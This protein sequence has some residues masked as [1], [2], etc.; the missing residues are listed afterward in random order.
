MGAPLEGRLG[1]LIEDDIGF[2]VIN[3]EGEEEPRL[4]CSGDS[5]KIYSEDGTVFDGVVRLDS[6]ELGKKQYRMPGQAVDVLA[7]PANMTIDAWGWYFSTNYRAEFTPDPA[8]ELIKNTP[9]PKIKLPE[10]LYD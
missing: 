1:F 9:V 10:G 7:T 4:I 8:L 3:I 5:L 6:V 2:W